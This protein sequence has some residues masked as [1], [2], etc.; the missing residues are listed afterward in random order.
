[1]PPASSPVGRNDPCPCGSGL[2]YKQCHGA[3][4]AAMPAK[5]PE[6]L[7]PDALARRGLEAH[8]TG[9]LDAAE[10][11]YRAAIAGAPDLAVALHYLGVVLY[12]RNR[13]AEAMP[14]LDRAAALSP[15][16][17]EYHN[18]RG[19]ALV[20]LQREG[21]AIAEYRRTL[22]LKPTHAGAWNNLGLALQA[23]GEVADAIHA[24]REGLRIAPE[25]AQLHWNLS[26]ALLLQGDF[27]QGWAEYEWRLKCAELHSHRPQYA[28]P[29][30]TGDDPAG[31]TLLL[32]AEQGLGDTLQTLRFARAVA[33]RGARVIVAVHQPLRQLAA[34][35]PGVAE[36][37]AEFGELPPYDAHVSLMS[38]PG[39][40]GVTPESVGVPGPYLRPDPLRVREAK[41]AIAREG[42]SALKIGVA[43][44]GAAANTQNV[45]RSMAV[46][47]FA[48]LLDIP[49]TRWFSLARQSEALSAT[50]A[51]YGARLVALPMRNDFDGLAALESELDLVIS[52]DTSLA[53]VAGAL[54]K[55]V[56]VLLHHVPDWRWMLHRADSPWYPTARLFRQR[57]PGDWSHPL[58]E[59]EQAL[60]ALVAR[61][62]P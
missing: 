34:T 48:P 12:Q 22:A 46:A 25:F 56:W 29:R 20:A 30:W 9:D 36:A 37:H 55:P 62:R 40:L 49:G 18:N 57:V 17:P 3:L 6:P 44:A 52:V 42:G 19:L 10:Q 39:L 59:V 8:K 27:E 15:E 58:R 41:A 21:E 35:A 47:A 4:A 7:S 11:N 54:G 61:R 1:M 16:E 14:L 26:L 24:Y 2:R 23:T 50:D 43:W 33:D 32:T 38:L 31:R 60:R 13:P 28:G 5:A 53:H 51:P 45:K